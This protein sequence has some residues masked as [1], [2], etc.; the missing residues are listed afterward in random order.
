MEEGQYGTIQ[1]TEG[2]KDDRGE[3]LEICAVPELQRPFRIINTLL[4][5]KQKI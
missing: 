1:R 2:S 3:T 4:G 5:E